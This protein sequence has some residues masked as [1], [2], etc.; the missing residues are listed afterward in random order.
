MDLAE[1]INGLAA[2]AQLP[3][4]LTWGEA[5][6]YFRLKERQALLLLSFEKFIPVSHYAHPMLAAKIQPK[7]AE[8]I[9]VKMIRSCFQLVIGKLLYSV[10]VNSERNRQVFERRVL[11][12]L[13]DCCPIMRSAVRVYGTV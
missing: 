11:S 3:S 12:A 8:P 5:L 2:H 9:I 6:I 4:G 13:L 7:E 1:L 10:H